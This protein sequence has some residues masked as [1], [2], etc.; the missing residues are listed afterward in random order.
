[1]KTIWFHLQGYRELP[2]DFEE[3]Y[4]SVW[5]SPPSDE[6]C[7]PKRVHEF[8]NWNLDELDYA[9][10][11][12]YDG[13]G[14]NEHHQ[15]GYGFPCSP[16]QTAYYLAKS[17]TDQAIVILGDTLPLYNPPLR[18]AEELAFVDCLSNGRCVAG[19]P[20]GSPMDVA[21]CYG[22]TP[23]QVRPR[24]Y[25]A[26]DLIKQAWTQEGPTHFN[27]KYTKLRNINIWPKPIQDP[28]PPIWLAGGGSV[29]T[30]EFAAEQD[31]TYSFLSFG[32]RAGAKPQ[33]DGFWETIARHGKDENPYRAGFAQ[34]V[35][36]GETDAEAERLYLD[37]ARYF[38]KKSLHI[39][40]QFSAV[41]G[42]MT[43]KSVENII[44]K[45]SAA[46]PFSS[47]LDVEKM[48][49][50]DLVDRDK[51]IIGGSPS[52]VI[53][54]IK[55]LAQDLHVGHLIL[56]MQLGSMDHELT[57][58]NT[59]LFAEKVMPHVRDIWDDEWED[60]WWPS[61]AKRP[62]LPTETTVA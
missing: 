56:I 35:M 27:G 61:G 1:M 53:D 20:V 23:T 50:S 14:T 24:Y 18:V 57:K 34:I 5:V 41:A 11:L 62:V 38:Y 7:D 4:E 48:K 3:R 37:H 36:V 17:T 55:E 46:N 19:M 8:L 32:G 60:H 9:A 59:R 58:Y 13:I 16:N 10:Q 44:K 31:Y 54:Q 30:W 2:P 21:H 26:H 39:A 47:P 49:W 45:G 29:E 15:N 12:G 51:R 28:H 42:Y 25:E 40:S 43:K 22:I 33:M 6:L 52:T